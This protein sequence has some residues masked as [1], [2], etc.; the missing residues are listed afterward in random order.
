MGISFVMCAAK[1][2][3]NRYYFH[4]NC[5]VDERMRGTMTE[6]VTKE[7]REGKRMKLITVQTIKHLWI[8]LYMLCK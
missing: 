2:T 6:I 8:E 4:G 7:V 3:N 5:K 1:I